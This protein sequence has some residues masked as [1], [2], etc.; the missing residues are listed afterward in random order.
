[1]NVKAPIPSGVG[2]RSVDVT[3]L[4]AGHPGSPKSAQAFQRDAVS[5]LTSI[6][7]LYGEG[8]EV[9][10]PIVSARA[11]VL[12]EKRAQF[13]EESFRGLTIDE[14][15]MVVKE[16][17]LEN[18]EVIYGPKGLTHWHDVRHLDARQRAAYDGSM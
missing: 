7:T 5:V 15:Q 12:V 6:E 9:D 18:F 11:L 16:F 13:G 14:A 17:G 10:V 2:W 1:M 4:F 3:K 8:W